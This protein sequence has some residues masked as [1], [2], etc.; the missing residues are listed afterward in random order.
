[1]NAEPR[2][3]RV[4]V[5]GAG[6]GGLA[7]ACALQCTPSRAQVTV[8][9]RDDSIDRGLGGEIELRGAAVVEVLQQLGLTWQDLRSLSRSPRSNCVP[10]RALRHAL[11]NALS[12]HAVVRY[13]VR[14]V[15][16]TAAVTTDSPF[17]CRSYAGPL[18]LHF[19]D[20]TR[21]QHPADLVIDGGGLGVPLKP[22]HDGNTFFLPKCGGG[23]HHRIMDAHAAIGDA[24]TARVGWLPDFVR[25]YRHGA[26]GALSDGLELGT[27]LSRALET[28]VPPPLKVAC[29]NFATGSE[30]RAVLVP[31]DLHALLRHAHPTQ[32]LGFVVV[33]CVLYTATAWPTRI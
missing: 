27:R 13:G 18:Y 11:R 20:G 7:C 32:A 9:E 15:R 19:E 17:D 29:G 31:T 24:R 10:V 14:V 23:A 2:P 6:Y 1:M 28:V 8:Y 30:G 12:E 21:S 26:V 25:R 22:A 3:L 33:C 4:A 16:L 5:V